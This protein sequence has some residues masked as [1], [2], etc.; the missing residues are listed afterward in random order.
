MKI[1]CQPRGEARS[2]SRIFVEADGE[3]LGTLPV[4]ISAVPDAVTLLV[5]V[6]RHSSAAFDFDFRGSIPGDHTKIESQIKLKLKGGGQECP[7]HTTG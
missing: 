4:E 6:W 3:L 1:D 5:P 7:P 2:D